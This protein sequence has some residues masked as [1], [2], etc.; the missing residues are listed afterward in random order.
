MTINDKRYYIID[1][2]G[3]YYKLG[4]DNNLVFAKSSS[5]AT[6]FTIRE[7][8]LRIG[9]GRKAKFYTILEAEEATAPVQGVAPDEVYNAPEYDTVTKPT[10][11]D[12]LHNNWEEKLSEL[13]Y[14]SN[15]IREY[16][17]DLNQML[18]DVDKEICDILH[19]IEFYSPDD[20]KLLQASKMLQERRMR[21]REIKDEMEKTALM[22]ET[23]LDGTF[24]IKVH[25]SLE[26]MERMKARIYTPRKLSDL[27]D[28]QVN[29]A[30]A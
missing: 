16:Q 20:E 10:M 29:S 30:I 19:F 4:S 23:F 3:N 13:C 27:F 7:A 11:F 17:A 25:Q 28:V 26:Q 5:E 15:H 21:R 9:S 14:M 12:T 6:S 2:H 1:T 22:R 8:N 24:R 18:S